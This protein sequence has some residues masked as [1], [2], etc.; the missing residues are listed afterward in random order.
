MRGFDE[1]AQHDKGWGPR[2]KSLAANLSDG[3]K[4]VLLAMLKE[5]AEET[6]SAMTTRGS[7]NDWFW[8]HLSNVGW[9]QESIDTVPEALQANI[10]AYS[11]TPDGRR[12]LPGLLPSFF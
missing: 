5:G 3:D 12:L 7:A 10:V 8:A 1:A 11:I 2:L 9:M 6:A 4:S